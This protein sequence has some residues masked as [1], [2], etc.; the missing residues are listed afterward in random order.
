MPHQLLTNFLNFIREHLLFDPSQKILLAV[1]GGVDSMVMACL[2]KEAGFNAGIA[3][4]NFQLRDEE[5]V[6]D[7]SFV[8]ELAGRLEL[9]FHET[10]FDTTEYVAT[11]KVSIQIA[12]RELRYQWLEEVRVA[13]G[14]AYIATAH[15]LQDSVETALMNFAKGTGI[16]GLHGILPKYDKIIR[17]MLFAEK[18]TL[19]AWATRKN[20]QFVEDSSNATDKYTRNY[21]RHHVIPVIQES[22]PAAV[23]NMAGTIEKIREAEVLYQESVTRH[24]KAL[25]TQKEDHWMIPVLKLQKTVPLQTIAWEIFREFGCSSAQLPQVLNLLESE[26][27]R[28]VETPTHRILRN[29]A[30]LL[31]TALQEKAAPV[32]SISNDT[33]NV[34]YGGGQLHLRHIDKSHA[35][36]IPQSQETAWVDAS[37]LRYPLIL[38]K[39]K[40]GDYFYPLGMRKKKKLSRFFID[41]KLSIPEKE[42]VWVL[43]SQKRVVW[44][45]GMRIDDRFKILPS[46]EKILS[47]ELHK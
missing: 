39:W 20:L 47:I 13:N 31:I 24:R 9:P 17:P 41:Q 26:S 3:H 36:S 40:Q 5:S 42:Q 46:T 30:W 33:T 12:A 23:K 44:V 19:V 38:R 1:S 6:R 32:I 4:C 37:Q 16:A 11:H 25:L 35:G 8:R 29:R 15:H 27:G 10:R 21:F 2:F 22:I 14:Y 34:H 18:D 28:Y 7:E 43:E 45:I